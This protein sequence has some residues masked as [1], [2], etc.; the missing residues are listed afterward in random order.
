[1]KVF[2]TSF[3]GAGLALAQGVYQAS[4]LERQAASAAKADSKFATSGAR[5]PTIAMSGRTSYPRKRA[6]SKKRTS[7]TVTRAGSSARIVRYHR[8][9]APITFSIAG[10]ATNVCGT[11]IIKLSDVFTS[12]ILAMY[13][14][15]R[16]VKAVA[17]FSPL[18]DPGNNGVS[19][20]FVAD[21]FLANEPTGQDA[22]ATNAQDLSRY[23]NY[24]TM[25]IV[26]GRYMTYTFYPKA[27]NTISGS[28]GSV[29]QG[30]Y[31][32]GNPWIALSSAGVQVPHYNLYYAAKTAAAVGASGVAF[33]LTW[34]I[35]FDC[36]GSR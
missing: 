21:C 15:Y 1:M 36:I 6:L 33:R 19:G 9:S 12:D 22:T 7:R 17:T 20:N 18:V 23:A 13:D 5:A 31:G 25:P 11:Q 3:L 26:S 4:K 34:T 14:Q 10:A 24:K 28:A 8:T 2:P 32:F 27:L 29:N 16:V 30:S 35:Y